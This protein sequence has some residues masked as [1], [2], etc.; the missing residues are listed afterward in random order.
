MKTCILFLFISLKV[1]ANDSTSN[2]T[3]VN[4]STG[5][6]LNILHQTNINDFKKIGYQYCVGFSTEKKIS[7]NVISF[8]LS[9]TQLEINN[10]S[11]QFFDISY[12]KGLNLNTNISQTL[13]EIPVIYKRNRNR[14]NYG[15]GV[16]FSYLL[17]S[18]LNQKVAANNDLGGYYDSYHA[19]YDIRNYKDASPFVKTNIAPCL[20]FGMKLNHRLS[21]QFF[22][23][24]QLL[25]N[26][27]NN[28]KFNAFNSIS[29]SIFFTYQIN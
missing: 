18:N 23:S 9:I 10:Y 6:S 4:V 13:V 5:F 28:Y 22:S 2:K 20:N 1:F 11:N 26:P 8:G 15:I 12:Q 14:L 19:V 29:N 24:Y 16:F 27:V 17:K 21:L 7:K 25:S 3:I